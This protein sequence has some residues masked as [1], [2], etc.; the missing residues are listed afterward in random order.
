[1]SQRGAKSARAS[2]RGDARRWDVFSLRAAV[3]FAL[4]AGGCGDSDADGPEL[5]GESEA[6]DSDDGVADDDDDNDDATP[7]GRDDAS[8]DD[9][10]DDDD[11]DVPEPTGPALPDRPEDQR[12]LFVATTGGLTTAE[13]REAP[14][15]LSES[16]CFTDLPNLVGTADVVP[17][18]INA[19]LWTDGAIKL[20][21]IHLP[22]GTT[23]ALLPN[24]DITWPTGTVMFKH[25]SL[26]AVV[27][28]P[29]TARPIETRVMVLEADGWRFFTYVWTDDG[30]DAERL[31]DGE[32][33]EVPM[34]DDSGEELL[35]P[36]SVPA[37][38]DCSFCHGPS[39][40]R[41][42]GPRGPQLQRDVRYT[43]G[44]F[45]QLQALRDAGWLVPAD[46]D[47]M[48]LEPIADPHDDEAAI[49]ARA[50]AVLHANCSHCHRPGGWVPAELKM[51]LRY[52]TPLSETVACDVPRRYYNPWA[53]GD[54]RIDP[55]DPDNSF[56]LQRML[57]RGL[58]QMPP[59][60]T[61]V[62]DD[63]GTDVVAEWIATLE[64]C[65]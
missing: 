60:A 51:D 53:S 20:R 15:W 34:L 28:D 14:R 44:T 12:C 61:F 59:M 3:V 62:V 7:P 50:R 55:G 56:V 45:N 5:E 46:E 19:P 58:G 40:E 21:Q 48:A 49:E 37:E 35:L 30:K 52:D 10:G 13:R 64:D 57:V 41:V 4:V 9:D 65:D 43:N 11:D 24:G 23:M 27:D 22:A 36:Y 17:Y 29:T 6:A 33:L 42:L 18:E 39:E 8:D 63:D 31:I 2:G 1:V 32:T 25:F 38:D 47:T 54:I 16:R 26:P